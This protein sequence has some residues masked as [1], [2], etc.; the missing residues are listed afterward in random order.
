MLIDQEITRG[1]LYLAS[2][3]PTHEFEIRRRMPCV[4]V[5]SDELNAHLRTFNAAP[6]ASAATHTPFAYFAAFSTKM[7]AWFLIRS[8]LTIR[9][10]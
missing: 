8:G 3:N 10:S 4:V 2:L 9:I 5:A 7:G 6:L 1:E